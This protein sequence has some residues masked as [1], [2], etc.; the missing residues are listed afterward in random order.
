MNNVSKKVTDINVHIFNADKT[1]PRVC[2][3]YNMYRNKR[4]PYSFTSFY[5]SNSVVSAVGDKLNIVNVENSNAEGTMM[6]SRTIEADC[7]SSAATSQVL[8]DFVVDTARGVGAE[9]LNNA[10]ICAHA[11]NSINDIVVEMRS[12]ILANENTPKRIW[13]SSLQPGSTSGHCSIQGSATRCATPAPTYNVGGKQDVGK[14]ST[15]SSQL[16]L[17]NRVAEVLG[18]SADSSAR[19]SKESRM[20]DEDL[21]ISWQVLKLVTENNLDNDIK[22]VPDGEIATLGVSSKNSVNNDDVELEEVLVKHMAL[23]AL[24]DSVE[25]KML[26]DSGAEITVVRAEGEHPR[27]DTTE[28][29][30]VLTTA[31]GG[32]IKTYGMRWVTVT[33]GHH[34]IR[35][36]AYVADINRPFILGRDGLKMFRAWL[37]FEN[38]RLFVYAGP[39]CIDTRVLGV[40]SGLYT[41]LEVYEIARDSASSTA[42]KSF[43]IPDTRI[44]D[45]EPESIQAVQDGDNDYDRVVAPPVEGWVADHVEHPGLKKVLKKFKAVFAENPKA[46]PNTTK[47]VHAIY[48]T[49]P[50]IKARPYRT[51]PEKETAIEKELDM[52]LSNNIIRPS[53]SEWA[54]PVVVVKKSDG[55]WRFCVD[56]RALNACTVKDSYPLPRIDQILRVLA[57]HKY[58]VTLDL[59]SGFWQIKL[60]EASKHKTAFVTKRGLFEFNV[61]EFGLVNAPSTFQRMME[62]V[63]SG[64]LDKICTV[65]ID[66]ITIFADSMDVLAERLEEVFSRL[67]KFNLSVKRSKCHFAATQ[68]KHLG[69][70][71]SESGI[72]SDPEKVRAIVEYPRLNDERQV[73]AFLG[74]AGYYRDYIQGFA[75]IAA[76]LTEISSPSKEF[77]W[78]AECEEAFGKLKQA[79][80]SAPVLVSPKPGNPY[81]VSCDASAVGIGSV[82]KQEHGV[83]EFGSRALTKTERRYT[84]TE[85]ECLAVVWGVQRFSYL[86]QGVHFKVITDHQALKWLK[87]LKFEKLTGAHGRLARWVFELDAYD[88]E[89]E[90]RPGSEQG[91][92]DGLSRG[93]LPIPENDEEVELNAIEAWPV[94]DGELKP[95]WRRFRYTDAEGVQKWLDVPRF[96][97]KAERLA[98]SA[99]IN[100]LFP[101]FVPNAVQPPDDIANPPTEAE[102]PVDPEREVNIEDILDLI[103]SKSDA[104]EYISMI[105]KYL[106]L[107]ELPDN[108]LDKPRVARTIVRDAEIYEVID[109]VLFRRCRDP[110]AE[111]NIKLLPV[112]PRTLVSHVVTTM[113]TLN[114]HLGV[115]RTLEQISKRFWWFGMAK[116]VS[117]ILKACITCQRV[118]GGTVTNHGR[119]RPI[120]AATHP[121]QRV[122]CDIVGPLRRTSSGAKYILVFTDYLTRYVQIYAL[123]NANAT[124]VGDCLLDYLC[125]FGPPEQLL[126]DR[127]TAF[128]NDVIISF[129]RVFSIHKVNTSPYHPQTD[130]LVER[131]NGTME[132][133]LRA[134]SSREKKDW[135]RYLSLVA[136]AYNTTVHSSTHAT[137][138]E[139][140]F[141]QQCILPFEVAMHNALNLDASGTVVRPIQ[142]ARIH[143][144]RSR[145]G[146]IWARARRWLVKNQEYQ[147]YYY[148]LRRVDKELHDGDLVLMNVYGA[149]HLNDDEEVTKKLRCEWYGP[150]K[151]K[152]IKRK[153]PVT[154]VEVIDKLNY[155]L[156]PAHPDVRASLANGIVHIRRIKKLDLLPERYRTKPGEIELYENDLVDMA[157][158][159]LPEE[160]EPEPLIIDPNPYDEPELLA[161]QQAAVDRERQGAAP[162]NQL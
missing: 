59:A 16:D 25:T 5:P 30:R 131:F 91:D 133:M 42:V 43:D 119:L 105:K 20:S 140:M 76:P 154:Q 82:L 159:D 117:E 142:A 103:K 87:K 62:E 64:L 150:Y 36:K 48:T 145:M 55:T 113:H 18:I 70:L 67:R 14:M 81:V 57:G 146:N 2:K 93:P 24:V 26:V 158:P 38:D 28:V 126:S 92:S 162:G 138:Y 1:H 139:L 33:I 95:G 121:G 111:H 4:R 47:V 74:L 127:G 7:T 106:L 96:D 136:F 137:P 115:T 52:M 124:Q 101:V 45:K 40:S 123:S 157:E 143:E 56:Y 88:M 83:I 148:N 116:D 97:N 147:S 65:Y 23:K 160:P 69:H 112:V 86:I 63:L 60:E 6:H 149:A 15:E 100:I 120:P 49:G 13:E 129:Q 156:E 68:A 114:N 72:A 153:D 41:P 39:E 77:E 141:G 61:V 10:P 132:Q 29:D 122:A 75:T 34:M 78:T 50:P 27:V 90:H 44:K 11:V 17:I 80:I 85:R 46:P 31:H 58:Y 155:L 107:H 94:E 9:R 35:I 8:S 84:A 71:I 66:D 118:K 54:S 21:D 3:P 110:L 98:A 99:E 144:L 73:R 51:T 22:Y 125:R 128:L 37:N 108:V 135:D 89:I 109:G 130:G 32:T 104:D 19:E 161:E 53:V 12:D 102:H 134:Y 79:L 151:I 152:T